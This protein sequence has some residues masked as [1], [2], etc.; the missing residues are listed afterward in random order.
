MQ[1]R[2]KKQTQQTV[3]KWWIENR[4][5]Q[6]WW[7]RDSWRNYAVTV[8]T[9]S[10][11]QLYPTSAVCLDYQAGFLDASWVL[12]IYLWR[13]K[14]SL[15]SKFQYSVILFFVGFFFAHWSATFISLK[16]ARKF[17]VEAVFPSFLFV[18]FSFWTYF[19]TETSV[20]HIITL[21]PSMLFDCKT[22]EVITNHNQSHSFIISLLKDWMFKVQYG[23]I[24]LFSEESL[25]LS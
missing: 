4:T 11:H 3:R 7:N 14:R 18:S 23:M 1:A 24:V 2:V 10:L 22:C 15:F 12:F 20:H 17:S 16:H 21:I 13:Q 8:P 5:A 25:C 6:G 9:Q 19:N